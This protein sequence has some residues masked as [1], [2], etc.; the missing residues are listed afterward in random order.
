MSCESARLLA[1]GF[2]PSSSLL[3]PAGNGSWTLYP[4][5]AARPRPI[6]TNFRLPIRA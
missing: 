2:Q 5:T 4:F 3:T 1:H 6:F